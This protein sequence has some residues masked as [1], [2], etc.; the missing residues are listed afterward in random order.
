MAKPTAGPH[1]LPNSP[2]AS[3]GLSGNYADAARGT[4][5]TADQPVSPHNNDQVMLTPATC[6]SSQSEAPIQMDTDGAPRAQDKRCD[7]TQRSLQRMHACTSGPTYK[8]GRHRPKQQIVTAEPSTSQTT[9]AEP[10]DASECIDHMNP[11]RVSASEIAARTHHTG[12]C[13]VSETDDYLSADQRPT[14]TAGI[15]TAGDQM[16]GPAT[17]PSPPPDFMQEI[18]YPTAPDEAPKIDRLDEGTDE[19][20]DHDDIK[21]QPLHADAIPTLDTAKWPFPHREVDKETAYVYDVVRASGRHNH[22]QAKILL[23]TALNIDGWKQE[24]TGHP[25]DPL[26]M[27]GI[28][29]GFPIQYCGPPQYTQGA[30]PNH[31]SARN[32][33]SHIRKYVQEE[34]R[35]GALEGP[36]SAP[37]FTPWCVVSPL[38]SREKAGS[39]DRRIIVDLSFP[40]GGVNKYIQPHIFNGEEATHN[41]PTIES[42]VD[43]ISH[44][45]PGQVTMAVVDLS[46]AYRQFPV[47]PLDWPLLG[48]SVDNEYFFDRRM[49]FGARM[50]S[51]TM[52]TL[53]DFV[54]RALNV[55]GIKAHM[56][57]DDIIV[58][59]P[60]PQVAERQYAQTLDLIKKLGLQV[61]E[62]KLQKPATKVKWLGIEIDTA[63]NTLA[64]PQEKLAEIKRCMAA[65]A[66]RDSVTKKQLQRI[67]GMVNHLAKVVRAARLFIGRILAA[68]RAAEGDIV[69]VAHQVRSDVKWFARHLSAANG[70]AIIPSNRVVLR[71][72]ADACMEGAGASD[73]DRFYTFQ[74]PSRMATTH[75]IA[76]LEAINCVAAARAFIHTGHAGGTIELHCDNKPSIDAFRSGRARDPVLAA[77]S[78]ALW[79]RAAETDT[80]I[81]FTHVPGEAMALPDALSRV[82]SDESHRKLAKSLVAS[83][84]LKRVDINPAMFSYAAFL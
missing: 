47:S 31:A 49:P 76:H 41:L 3:T 68:Y 22:E 7:Q 39:T 82:Y 5:S 13:R 6:H 81:T 46:R 48:I 8:H 79:Y 12:V 50:S 44:M 73:G 54:V 67:I 83:L 64:I 28:Q 53:A 70:R 52:Q 57:L 1:G 62:K 45:C 40:D 69:P 4:G 34:T 30:T 17:P 56:Y 2:S 18:A 19:Y 66:K 65:A 78:R 29:F 14:D 77:C 9:T 72:W 20:D 26:I 61:A 23:P 24:A 33:Q 42:A 25:Q 10:M 60:T 55:R 80:S 84:K 59:G 74:L 38:M 75:H 35:H 15:M 32:H 16:Q 71:I 37:P 43:T 58:V 21:K 36:F 11:L 27:Q 63:N 51:F